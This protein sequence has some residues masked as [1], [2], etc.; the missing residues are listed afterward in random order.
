MTRSKFPY[1][2][3]LTDTF[4]F[5]F[6]YGILDFVSLKLKNRTFFFLTMRMKII[7]RTI[8]GSRR[9]VRD[10]V[11]GEL[12]HTNVVEAAEQKAFSIKAASSEI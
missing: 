12:V 3:R 10:S 6:Y 1:T 11:K 8:P 5:F 2:V 4:N 9:N 7:E